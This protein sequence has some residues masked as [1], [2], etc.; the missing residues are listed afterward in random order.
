[1]LCKPLVKVK[2]QQSDFWKVGLTD[3]QSLFNQIFN[4]ALPLHDA[5]SNYYDWVTPVHSVAQPHKNLQQD[6][7]TVHV[8]ILIDDINTIQI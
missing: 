4:Y 2:L 6:T 1:M 3:A 7:A 5:M 8:N